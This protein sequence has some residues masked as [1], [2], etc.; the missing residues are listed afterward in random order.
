[1]LATA[2]IVFRESLEAALF[3]GIVA[4][5]TRGVAG[6]DR[7]LA[8]GIAAGVLGALM[9][10]LS[11]ERIAAWA[12]GLGQDLVNVLILAAAWTMLAWHCIWGSQHGLE[13]ASDA[14][15]MGGEVSRGVR[16]PIVLASA[17]ALA[18]LREGAEAVL[19]V[20][21]I[22]A[23]EGSGA[24]HASPWPGIALGL[25]AGIAMGALLYFGLSRIPA[26]R[27][28]AVTQAL[29]V[30]VTAAVASQLARALSQAG[31]VQML[32]A[33]LWDSSNWLAQDSPPGVLLH[34]L[35]G[36]DARP[37]GLQLLFYA[38]TLVV[39]TLASR[40]PGL[41]RWRPVVRT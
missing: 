18:V 11:A 12:D 6:R 9:L 40:R 3:V 22:A 38:G 33:S 23:G 35:A 16:A 25:A 7:W 13:A 8:G 1:M 37:S 17:C 21:G 10:A 24:T 26:R 30:L 28:F 39:I 32:G 2:V 20:L 34:A 31:W 41:L 14:G 15:R 19:F 36:Y 5:A 4:A 29:I 27:V